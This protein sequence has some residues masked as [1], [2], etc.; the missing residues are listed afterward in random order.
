MNSLTMKELPVSERPYEKCLA[1]G[2]E[3]LSNAELLAVILKTGNKN[4]S[5]IELA[6][7][8]LS[9][10]DSPCTLSDIFGASIEE[11]TEIDGIGKIK[12]INLKCIFELSKRIAKETAVN[13]IRLSTSKTIADY[14]MEAMRHLEREEIR[15]ALFD[16]KNNLIKD[17]LLSVGTVN[18]S[19]ITPREIFLKAL[20]YKAVYIVL[21]HNHPSG[22]PTPSSDDLLI[23]ARIKEVGDMLQLP[24]LDHIIIGDNKYTSLR[25]QGIV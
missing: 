24:L 19:L 14:Y 18:A 12:A 6:Y 15:A 7:K 1:L 25:D 20:S 10:F 5:A 11:L 22:D 16:T 4:L 3:S 9:T 2:E 21:V 8:L 23:T 17:V 13:R